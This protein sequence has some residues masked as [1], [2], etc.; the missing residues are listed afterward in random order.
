[1]VFVLPLFSQTNIL[2]TNPVAEDIM[3]G[4]YNPA[5]YRPSGTFTKSQIVQGIWNH[6]STDSMLTNLH[7]LASFHNRNTG[8][9]TVSTTTGIG[10]ARRWVYGKFQQYA[11]QAQNRLVPSYLQFDQTI[12][13]ATQ[14]RNI[15]AV[16][17]GT[18]TADK[19]II[20]IEAHMDSRC[21]SVCDTACTAEGM[22]DNG[23]GTVLV[24]ELARV[25]S[26]YSYKQSIVF[27]VT[28]GEEQG[29]D[30][31]NAF[32]VYCKNK[33]IKIEAV[34]NN[35]VVGGIICGKTAS[36]PGCPGENMIDSMSVRLF[37]SAT[38]YSPHKSLVRFIKLE[39]QEEVKPWIPVPTT[40]HIM[41]AE[42]RTGRGG[43][44]IPFR[45][46][47][48]PAMRFTSTYEDGDA[49]IVPGYTDRQH[50]TR[51]ILGKDVNMDG[52]FDSFYVDVNYLKRNAMINANT[53]TMAAIGPQQ[54]AGMELVN[55]GNGI[56]VV[57]TPAAGIQTH[58]IGIRSASNDF[59]SVYTLTGGYSMKIYNVKKDS[60]YFISA[61][62]VDDNGTES[63]F[64]IEKFVKA[65]Q[66]PNSGI[67]ETAA[68]QKAVEL[69][70]ATPNPFDETTT[71]SVLVNRNIGYHSATIN[72]TDIQGRTVKEIPI[73]LEPGIN[74]VLYEHGF[75][76]KGIFMY[77]LLIDGKVLQSGK[78]VFK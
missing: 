19:S 69:L 9:D 47:G 42:D 77:S 20:L 48:Y 76:Q 38:N 67:D 22:E 3:L 63:I 51:D 17:P 29:L 66:Q 6:L 52:K 58:R 56:T 61:A 43:D 1:M 34:L 49:N 65:A 32:A 2:S 59:D 7:T 13:T 41:N 57:L 37:S 64:T 25:M 60:I 36:P 8:S 44:H 23:S 4:K 78:M 68:S 55:D 33:G 5:S 74:E 46:N 12:C 62:S 24:M 14:H 50:S 10:A 72:I 35:D 73:K 27:V 28:I 16:L 53:A 39:Y 75:N 26:Q 18:D 30:G 11:W 70:G 40:L 71:L 45:I 21:E 31:A 54:P 15:F